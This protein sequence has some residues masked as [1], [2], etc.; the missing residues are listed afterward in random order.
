SKV[1]KFLRSDELNSERTTIE[2]L[3]NHVKYLEHKARKKFKDSK[4]EKDVI[5]NRIEDLNKK[6]KNLRKEKKN[7]TTALR[8]VKDIMNQF[9]DP[10]TEELLRHIQDEM[11]KSLRN[12]QSPESESS[13]EV[14]EIFDIDMQEVEIQD[15]ETKK[16]WNNILDNPGVLLEII[17]YLSPENLFYFM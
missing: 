11:K 3:S 5:L 6:I 12:E 4:L 15:V 13:L 2:F 17:S 10:K 1:K 14:F 9:K 8:I 16:T 7:F